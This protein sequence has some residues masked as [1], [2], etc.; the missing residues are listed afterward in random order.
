MQ[1]CVDIPTI[2]LVL[3]SLMMHELRTHNQENQSAAHKHVAIYGLT[4][5]FLHS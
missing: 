2:I 5:M 3:R 4:D 1:V